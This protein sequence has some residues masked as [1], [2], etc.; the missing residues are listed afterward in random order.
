MVVRNG[1]PRVTIGQD[2][3]KGDVLVEGVMEGIY[4]GVRDVCA[5]ADITG[6]VYVSKEKFEN[7][8]QENKVKTGNVET[9]FSINIKKNKINFNKRV[10]KFKK[11]DTIRT[12]NKI[13]LFSKFLFLFCPYLV[14]FPA[15]NII[16]VTFLSFIFS[17]LK[18]IHRACVK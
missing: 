15:T 9:D 2:V 3:K 16:A 7:F 8:V 10:S 1:T 17:L 5:D 14:L 12:N 4:K 6:V 18:L 11:Y 13:K